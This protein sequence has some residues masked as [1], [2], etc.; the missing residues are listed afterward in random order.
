MLKTLKFLMILLIFAIP[1][2]NAQSAPK[3]EITY[4]QLISWSQDPDTRIFDAYQLEPFIHVASPH[5]TATD[6]N[7][8]TQDQLNDLLTSLIPT[9][10]SRTILYCQESFF[11]TRMVSAQSI[12]QMVLNQHG[13]TNIYQLEKLWL[14]HD[15]DTIKPMQQNIESLSAPIPK[16]KELDKKSKN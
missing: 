9:K 10:N 11:P 4:D 1:Q 7:S 3:N 13:Y 6:P 2:A 16:L 14:K 12:I 5:L 8:I 15:G